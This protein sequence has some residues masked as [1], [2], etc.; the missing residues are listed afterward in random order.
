[1]RKVSLLESALL[2]GFM[3]CGVAATL[4][5]FIQLFAIASKVLGFGMYSNSSFLILIIPTLYYCF[6]VFIMAC[7][8]L[9]ITSIKK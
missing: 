5:F 8:L 9:T 6:F 4:S 2:V 7:C 3:V 1:M